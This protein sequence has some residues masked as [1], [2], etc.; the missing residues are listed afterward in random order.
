MIKSSLNLFKSLSEELDPGKLQ[1][2]FLQSLLKLQDVERGSIWI[3]KDDKFICIEA[4]GGKGKNIKGIRIDANEPSI[5]GWVIENGKMTISDPVTDD[6]HYRGI[7]NKLSVKSSLILCFPLLLRN[8]EVYGAV[9]IIDTSPGKSKINLDHLY[10]DH[11]QELVDIGSLALNNAITFNRQL[12]ETQSL[13]HTLEEIRATEIIIGQNSNFVQS[14]ELAK[15]Y[16][17]TDFPV[18]ITGESGTGKELMAN[19]I[20]QLSK[21]SHKPFFVQNCSAIPETLLESELF[22]YKKGAFSGASRDKTGLF[23][24]A[25]KGTVFLDEIGDM[26][27]N[28]QA[29]ILRVIQNNEIKML[30]D[31]KVKYVDIRIVSATN[32][33]VKKLVENNQFRQDLFFRLSVLPLHIPPLRHRTDDIPMLL[34]HFLNK[35]A[36]KLDIPPKKFH[37]DALQQMMSHSWPGNIRELENF[38]RYLLV[39]INHDYIKPDDIPIHFFNV[40]SIQKNETSYS[41]D[42]S[43]NEFP[44]PTANRFPNP[45]IQF[46]EYSWEEVEKAYVNFL[47]TKYSYNITKAA[48]MSGINRS[49]F[50]SR[51][52]R[53][54][55]KTN[56]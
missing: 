10:L 38:V 25:H 27:V 31:P 2:K 22:G 14:L 6:R 9:Q 26:P 55:I 33:N 12:K 46:G 16:A 56:R 17:K 44:P 13:K 5:V 39:V 11:L 40:N 50:A 35:E 19:R 32:R 52:K 49:T 43:S 34:N 41:P 21:R 1:R 7:E 30:G 48:K 20:H 18:L 45:V 4:A 54:D 3:K 29:R 37:P 42:N 8:R 36:L 28:L 51:M 47:L 23:E 15:N 24:A 53:L